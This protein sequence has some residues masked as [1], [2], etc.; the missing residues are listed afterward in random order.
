[1]LPPKIKQKV[2]Q[3]VEIIQVA[4]CCVNHKHHLGIKACK[5]A[6]KTAPSSLKCLCALYHFY[7]YYYG[8]DSPWWYDPETR[9]WIGSLVWNHSLYCSGKGWA[10]QGP[11]QTIYHRQIPH[12]SIGTLTYMALV[13]KYIQTNKKKSVPG[14][15]VR[16]NCSCLNCGLVCRQ[17]TSQ[18]SG[19][20]LAWEREQQIFSHSFSV[21][22]LHFLVALLLRNRTFK[23]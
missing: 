23:G 15:S 9:G 13:Q 1:M 21:P 22:V 20:C 2:L 16:F 7:Y 19:P 18:P 14:I 17:A 6:F 11:A 8:K 5:A 4:H 12:R 3:G 10:A